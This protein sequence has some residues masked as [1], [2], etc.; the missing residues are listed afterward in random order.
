MNQLESKSVVV[1][2]ADLVTPNCHPILG[3][4]DCSVL[5]VRH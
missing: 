5:L 1:G 4:P 2:I 3:Y